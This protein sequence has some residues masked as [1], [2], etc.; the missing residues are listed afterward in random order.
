MN[1]IVRRIIAVAAFAA[2]PAYADGGGV[3]GYREAVMEAIGGHMQAMVGVLKGEVPHTSHLAAH[4]DALAASAEMVPVLFPA[5]SGEG[6]THAL[7]LIWEEPEAF[8]QKVE[9]FRV[10]A[11]AL[12]ATRGEM[13]AFA[14]ALQEVGK[15]CKGCHDR[16][17]EE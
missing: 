16:Y 13:P 4:A 10:A 15:S 8:N 17:K 5:G 3:Q 14:G 6:R 11:K 12:A 7:P 1:V 9:E 2:A